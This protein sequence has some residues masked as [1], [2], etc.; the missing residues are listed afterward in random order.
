MELIETG[1]IINT[2]GLRGDVKIEPWANSPAD[3]C[4]FSRLFLDGREHSLLSARASGRFVIAHLDGID[5]IDDAEAAKNKVVYVP[6]EDIELEEGEYLLEDLVG[7]EALDNESG[8]SLGRVV[9][10]LC[11]PGG[12]VLVIRGTREI[13]VPLRPEFVKDVDVEGGKVFI[14]LIEGM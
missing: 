7:L 3:F 13:L 1:R 8:A 5:S 4:A 6:R 11:P 10:I 2:H 14:A 9:E 12:D